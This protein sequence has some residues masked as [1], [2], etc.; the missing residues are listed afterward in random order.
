MFCRWVADRSTFVRILVS[1]PSQMF[2]TPSRACQHQSIVANGPQYT[3]EEYR[4]VLSL[5][6]ASAMVSLEMPCHTAAAINH[7][8]AQRVGICY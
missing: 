4:N 5:I 3:E 1:S 6:A 2:L 8:K 7:H